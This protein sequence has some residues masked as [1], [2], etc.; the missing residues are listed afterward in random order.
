MNLL[1]I[2]HKSVPFH[3]RSWMVWERMSLIWNLR[4]ILASVRKL[5]KPC[6]LI[7]YTS[8]EY[9]KTKHSMFTNLLSIN[10]FSNHGIKFSILMLGPTLGN[11]EVV[12]KHVAFVRHFTLMVSCSITGSLIFLDSLVSITFLML[13]KFSYIHK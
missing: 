13:P 11:A 8:L 6:L 5:K 4:C 9:F 12:Y 1:K 10:N 2:F 7:P 3:Y